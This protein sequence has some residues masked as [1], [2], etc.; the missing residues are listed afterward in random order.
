MAYFKRSSIADKLTSLVPD[1][2]IETQSRAFDV[3]QRERKI[4]VVCLVWTMILGFSA[5]SKR[6]LASLRRSYEAVSHQRIAPSSF[7][8]RLTPN[9]AAL[10]RW[11]LEQVL[12]AEPE[13][14]HDEYS[15]R[16][17]DSAVWSHSET[18]DAAV[19]TPVAITVGEPTNRYTRLYFT[20]RP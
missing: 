12:A 16:T 2:L 18:L 1:S 4:D 13:R 8:A 17:V 15:G 9:L 11:L 20:G 6:T 19:G 7:F 5:G 14:L 3:V 10:M